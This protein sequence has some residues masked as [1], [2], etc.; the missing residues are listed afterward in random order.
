MIKKIGN[1]GRKKIIGKD[2]EKNDT[3]DKS[4]KDQTKSWL[5]DNIKGRDGKTVHRYIDSF[6]ADKFIDSILL[7]PK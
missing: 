7:A 5:T 2:T 1:V 6:Y 4:T 3:T